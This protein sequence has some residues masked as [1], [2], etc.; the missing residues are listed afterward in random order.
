VNDF[1][2]E[3]EKIR[4]QDGYDQ[5]WQ[6]LKFAPRKLVRNNPSLERP[7]GQESA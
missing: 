6:K 3:L 4:A 2:E 5:H 7:C 1:L